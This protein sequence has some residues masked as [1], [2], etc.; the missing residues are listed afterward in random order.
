MDGSW[1]ITAAQPRLLPGASLNLGFHGQPRECNATRSQALATPDG[2]GLSQP[3]ARW[4]HHS[5]GTWL[6]VR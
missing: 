3:G 4:S 6:R 5:Y 2:R 1:S